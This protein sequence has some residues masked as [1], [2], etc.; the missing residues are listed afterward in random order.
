MC[1]LT[2]LENTISEVGLTSTAR[3]VEIIPRKRQTETGSLK[4]CIYTPL[5]PS[6]SPQTTP[7]DSSHLAEAKETAEILTASNCGAHSLQFKSRHLPASMSLQHIICPEYNPKL[8][9]KE[10]GKHYPHSREKAI[11]GD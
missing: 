4:Y 1:C 2:S 9:N 8:L 3:N 11:N 6:L 7:A 10:R 5:K